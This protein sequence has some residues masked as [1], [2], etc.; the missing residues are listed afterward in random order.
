MHGVDDT[1]DWLTVNVWP[2]IVAV[3]VRA[4]EDPFAATVIPTVAVAR[5]AGAGGDRE[6]RRVAR[7]GPLAAAARQHG[8]ARPDLLR[9]RS[10]GSSMTARTCNPRT[11]APAAV[12]ES[13]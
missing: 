8:R 7:R 4:A 1:P 5:A 11:G 2:A 13:V 10:T 9:R 12:C 3:P 6:P